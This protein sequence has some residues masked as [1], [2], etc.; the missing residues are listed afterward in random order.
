MEN[1]LLGL[2]CIF[3]SLACTIILLPKWIAAA[4]T[5]KLTGADMNKYNKK[6]V[7]EAGGIAVVLAIVFGLCALIFIKSFILKTDANLI[8]ILG[9]IA[10]ILLAGFLGFVDNILGWKKGISQ[11]Q[12]FLLTIPIALPLVVINVNHSTMNLPFV[13][14]IELGYLYPL[15]I[16][17]IGIVGATNGFNLVAGYN[18]LEAG[19]GAII[20]G[21][22]GAVAYANGAA[23]LALTCFIAVAALIGFLC[24]NVCPSKVFPGDSLT[25]PI[26]ALIACVAILGNMEKI[27]AFMFLIYVVDA[28]LYAKAKFIDGAGDVQAFAIP[29]ANN[30]LELPYKKLYDSTHI[31]LAALKKIKRKVYEK[32]IVVGLWLIQ[33]ALCLIV[34]RFVWL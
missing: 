18:G 2:F 13:G 9:I 26:G 16:V 3:S 23:W 21:A 22:L 8:Y 25:Y 7:A 4:K 6:Q 29:N 24:F 27:A 31:V 15:L 19:L 34:L 12:K 33:A 1:L 32:D 11:L 17:P 20:L 14:L 5:R 28:V 10:T 30:S